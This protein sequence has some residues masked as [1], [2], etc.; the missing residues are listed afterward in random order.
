MFVCMA[1]RWLA[2]L[3]FGLAGQQFDGQWTVGWLVSFRFVFISASARFFFGFGF[4]FCFA[5]DNWTLG[6]WTRKHTNK[7]NNGGFGFRISACASGFWFLAFC[8]GIGNT[9]TY[10]SMEHYPALLPSHFNS[11]ILW[12]VASTVNLLWLVRVGRVSLLSC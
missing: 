6:S 2:S 1:R 9:Y 12:T 10:I 8:Y 4:L 11:H 5:L 3:A 7:N